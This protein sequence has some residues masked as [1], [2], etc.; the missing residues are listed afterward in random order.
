MI[1]H[2]NKTETEGARAGPRIA[3]IGTGFSGVAMGAMLKRAG[4]SNFT[5]YEKAQEIGGT[6]RENT[7]PGVACDV[8]SHLYSLSFAPNPNWS[9]RFAPGAEIL[10]YV[11]G[12]ARDHDLYSRTQFGKEVQSA[13][14]NG[15]CW[16]LTFGDG[17]T[18]EYD[19]FISAVGGLHHPNIPVFEG[20]DD[21]KGPIVHTAKW[22]DDIDF[23]GKKVGVIGTAASA[24]QIIP[25]LAKTAAQVHVYQRT[26]GW[27]MPR[28]D[29]TYPALAKKIF[30]AFPFLARAYRGFYFAFLEWRFGAFQNKDNSAKRYVR[31]AFEKHMARTVPDLDFRAKITPDYDVGCKR[32]LSSDDY[33]PALQR[34]NVELI[35]DPIDR[36]T[37]DG[38]K[39]RDGG[40][41]ALD[42]II[43]ATGFKPFHVGDGMGIENADGLSIDDY[44][45][46]GV[47]AYKTVATPGFQNLFFLLGPN[48]GLGHNSVLL[49]IEAQANYILK[50]I[51]KIARGEVDLMA[52]KAQAGRNYDAAMQA[53]LNEM[54]WSSGCNSWYLDA[55]G[56]NY[57]LYRGSVRAFRE[58]L[59]EPDWDDFEQ[60]FVKGE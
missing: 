16:R 5:L 38:V 41:R 51:D 7:Y 9:K 45:A 6:W 42:V 1:T 8:P 32:A 20:Q 15:R 17:E 31:A 50:V 11:K 25:E 13:K 21:Y 24:V 57:T 26:P 48:S 47:R 22:R 35:T 56:R 59:K 54:V 53:G 29:Y 33:L 40:M 18:V 4:F 12:I 10:E 3:I 37:A 19:V 27:I 44:W 28:A 52:P 39:T 23:A 55:K 46:D 2:E 60:S 14:H 43:L 36:F 49:M 58:D 34:D 30:A